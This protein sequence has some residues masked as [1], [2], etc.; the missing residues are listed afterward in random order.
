V[1]VKSGEIRR[2]GRT[3]WAGNKELPQ[4]PF[5]QAA[6]SRHAL[7][8]KL[9]ELPAWDP[10]LNPVAGDAVAF[11]DVDIASAGARLGMLGPDVDPELILD[12]HRLLGD[13]A[14]ATE[15]GAWLDR[16]LEGFGRDSA[17]RRPPGEKGVGLLVDLLEEPI[18]LRC[19]D[20]E[21]S[22][23][24]PRVLP[25]KPSAGHVTVE[26]EARRLLPWNVAIVSVC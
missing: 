23:A 26:A 6:S 3:W 21:R 7:V 13:P 8:R 20:R 16:V 11:P 5:E 18:E 2:A 9:R 19:V 1:E 24:R 14:S 17:A 12:Q 4:S 15:L 10:T 25:S 22:Q